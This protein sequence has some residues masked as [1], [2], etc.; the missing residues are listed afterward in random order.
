MNLEKLFAE[1]GTPGRF[2]TRVFILLCFN[3]FPVVFNHVRMAFYGSRPPYKCHS[4]FY[5]ILN[6]KDDNANQSKNDG[7]LYSQH[8]KCEAIYIL[9]SG[10][11]MSVSCNGERKIVYKKDERDTSIV[12]E[13]G[14]NI[15]KNA[16]LDVFHF[17]PSA[18]TVHL[19]SDNPRASALRSINDLPPVRKTR[20]SPIFGT[21]LHNYE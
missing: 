18:R 11:N 6:T 8:E 2:Q 13:V 14:K 20:A 10:Q 21:E 3:Y 4:E 9:Y 12:T 5:D 15:Y 19:I 17:V 7:V 16:R 1:I